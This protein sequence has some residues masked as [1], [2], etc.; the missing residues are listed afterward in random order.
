GPVIKD[1]LFFFQSTEL[2]RVRSSGPTL[3]Y[4]PDPA[5]LAASDTN[6]QDFFNGQTVRSNAQNLGTFS[7]NQLTALGF[8]PC[9]G[10]TTGPC[11]AYNPDA[12]FFDKLS[13]NVPTDQGAEAPQDDYE[14]VGRIDWNVSNKT[15]VYGR[16]AFEKTNFPIGSNVNSVY[17]G[18][19]T[20]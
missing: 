16:Y 8:D 3:V 11:S 4:I 13:Y 6:T 15:Q 14:V 17:V 5:L 1:K 7:R 20:G 9:S 19:D 18:Y 12:P 2:L 10:R